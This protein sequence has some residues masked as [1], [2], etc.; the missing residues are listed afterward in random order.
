MNQKT[1]TKKPN[2]L[3]VLRKLIREEVKQAIK[4]EMVPILLEV[5]RAGNTPSSTPVGRVEV[6]YQ[7]L[8]TPLGSGNPPPVHPPAT[9]MTNPILEETRREMLA[10]LGLGGQ[11]EFSQ[12]MSKTS[13]TFVDNVNAFTHEPEQIPANDPMAQ[14]GRMLATA[15]KASKEELVEITDV[16]D[17]SAIM[18]QIL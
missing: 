16:P 5:I 10:N 12:M 18:K 14:V 3:D 8:Q 2:S 17:Y 9:S 11:D 4:E 15:R 7:N 1:T 6:G 13:P